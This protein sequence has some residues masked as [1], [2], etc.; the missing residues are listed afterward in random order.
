MDLE[1]WLRVSII[2]IYGLLCFAIGGRIIELTV[3]SDNLGWLERTSDPKNLPDRISENQISVFPYRLVIEGDYY[4]SEY[5]NS[6]SMLPTLDYGSNGIQITVN[7]KTELYIG[8]IISYIPVGQNVTI[9]HRIIDE[10]IDEQGKYYITRGDNL[11]T[12]DPFKIRRPQIKRVIV[13]VLW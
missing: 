8:D 12:S 13:G 7:D 2:V 1:R 10:G 3:Q 5:V 4:I 9:V 11:I 6:D